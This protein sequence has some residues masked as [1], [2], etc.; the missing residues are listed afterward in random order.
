MI[1]DRI[2]QPGTRAAGGPSLWLPQAKVQRV[3]LHWTAGGPY[4][5]MVDLLHYHLLVD[6]DG[7]VSRGRFPIGRWC[8]HTRMLNTGSVGL[9]ACGMAQAEPA[10]FHSGP[11]PLTEAQIAALAAAAARVLAHYGLPVTERTCLTHCEVPRVYGVEQ[12]GKWD[13]SWLPG[14]QSPDRQVAGDRLRWL[15]RSEVTRLKS[16]PGP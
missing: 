9:S 14:M 12:R 4:P 8:P 10:P 16:A 2:R 6:K 11:S 5:N 13:I 15:V 7:H 3:I 1:A